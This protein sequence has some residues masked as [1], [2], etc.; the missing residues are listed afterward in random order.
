MGRDL[1]DIGKDGGKA[2]VRALLDGYPSFQ[3][4][5]ARELDGVTA[6]EN[7][8]GEPEPLEKELD[9]NPYPLN[10]LPKGIKDAVEEVV[11]FVQ[12]PF[13]LAACSA[14]AQ[15]SVAGQGCANVC[16]DET[17]SGP[18]GVYLLVVAKSGERKS[19]VDK[20]L[21]GGIISYD[22]E[23][24]D[25]FAPK[26][27]EYASAL[28]SW[29]LRKKGI[30]N[31]IA[32]AAKKGE[33]TTE[34]EKKRQDHEATRPIAPR[35]PRLLYEDVTS[36]ELAF[37]LS[38]GWPSA[39]IMCSEGG[40]VLG[41]HAMQT[42]NV[43]KHFSLLNRLWSGER[44]VHSRRTTESFIVEGA[45]LTV[46]IAV[47]EEPLRQFFERTGG[48]AKGIGF[49]ARC[50]VACPDSTIGTRFYKEPPKDWPHLSRFHQ[51]T[52]KL[53]LD[54]PLPD[55]KT[56]EV[57]FARL[58]LSLE[59]KRC[60][61]AFANGTEERQRKGGDLEEFTDAGSKAADN[62]ARL[63]GLFHLYENGLGGDIDEDNME[64]AIQII[65]WHLEEARRLFAR[66]SLSQLRKNVLDLDQWL[67]ARCSEKGAAQV[68][69]GDVLQNG[70]YG[71][72]D[73]EAR[74]TALKTLEAMGR[75]RVVEG[76]RQKII[77]INPK[78]LNRKTLQ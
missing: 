54:A 58:K 64:R 36:E 51:T 16:R 65:D 12:C 59:A 41:S 9:S 50:L 10:A 26:K 27:R 28:S 55:P 49:L 14:L 19:Q 5:A 3:A 2:A 73:A 11:G 75:V 40:A 13:A 76:R 1:A 35:V 23:Q 29:E 53:L 52:K 67:L 57:A 62:A 78:L 6:Q 7:D 71:V 46:H 60:W 69:A 34:L 20:L 56:G 48:L 4:K 61:E 21:G 70:P 74:N 72:R 42:E 63:A 31:A 33:D 66:V 22:R 77:E 15:L 68:R 30:E 17:L 47:Q 8:W 37:Q 38:T 44:H 43:T 45:R 32:S 18:A 25:L 39:A 24:A